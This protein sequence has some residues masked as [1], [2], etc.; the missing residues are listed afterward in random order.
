MGL[1]NFRRPGPPRL[2]RSMR[3]AAARRKHPARG[4]TSENMPLMPLC[5]A[6]LRA[7]PPPLLQPPRAAALLRSLLRVAACSHRCRMLCSC[8]P[9][10]SSHSSHTHRTPPRHPHACL[11]TQPVAYVC[12]M[13]TNPTPTPNFKVDK[14][15]A[16]LLDSIPT[17]TCR[18]LSAAM[19]ACGVIMVLIVRLQR[20][21]VAL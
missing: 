3:R 20:E 15:P 18:A 21:R 7:L 8:L 11:P 1:R 2:A 16:S 13:S 12:T 6:T 14:T 4:A 17:A 9:S 10:H 19:R 5:P